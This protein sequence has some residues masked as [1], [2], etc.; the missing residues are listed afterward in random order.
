MKNRTE[1]RSPVRFCLDVKIAGVQ[2]PVHGTAAGIVTIQHIKQGISANILYT[3]RFCFSIM[4][5][6]EDLLKFTIE[7]RRER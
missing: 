1:E 4:I 5:D 3:I 7:R 6:K 2:P